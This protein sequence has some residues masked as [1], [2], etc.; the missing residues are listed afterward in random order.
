MNIG[1]NLNGNEDGGNDNIE[2]GDGDD[3][4]TGDK[5]WLKW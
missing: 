4:N 5:W 3:V 1:D 2:S